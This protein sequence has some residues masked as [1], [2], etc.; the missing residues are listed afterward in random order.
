MDMT[1]FGCG[2]ARAT[3][4]SP[5]SGSGKLVRLAGMIDVELQTV[6]NGDI[7]LEVATR[8]SGPLIVFVHGWPELWLSWRHQIDHVTGRGFRAAALDVRGYGGSSSPAEVE[9][10]TLRELAG[11][12]AAVIDA[13]SDDPAIVVGHDWGAPIAWNTARLHPDRVRAVMGMSVPY[14]PVGATSMLDMFEELYADRFFYMNYFQEPGVVE[15]ELDADSAL[16]LRTIFHG[17]SAAGSD[18]FLSPV[19]KPADAG[20]LDGMIDPGF[21]PPFI[22]GEEFAIY[23]DAFERGGWRGPINR[24]RALRLD[25]VDLGHEPDGAVLCQPAAFVGGEL[26]P[27]RHLVPGVDLFE[28][29]AMACADF[30]GSTIIDGVGHW[31]QQEASDRTNAAL[32]EFLGGL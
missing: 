18:V 26:D 21:P 32:D 31:V 13:L 6:T 27:V 16:S 25:S 30:R 22:P 11:D 10:Y 4:R 8:G 29:A 23:V 15:A 19:D 24:Y 3:R 28:Y 20:L 1:V 17:V 9:R 2:I 12:I 5:R 14:T 7:D